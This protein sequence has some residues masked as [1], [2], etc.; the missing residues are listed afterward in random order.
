MPITFFKKITEYEVKN[1][2]A[3]QKSAGRKITSCVQGV[4][5]FSCQSVASKQMLFNDGFPTLIFGSDKDK[6]IRITTQGKLKEMSSVWLCGGILKETYMDYIKHDE[7]FIVVRFHPASF[8]STFG[9][10]PTFFD[11]STLYN[12]NDIDDQFASLI[13]QFYQNASAAERIAFLKTYFQNFDGHS[14]MPGIIGEAIALIQCRRGSI[15]VAEV[16]KYFEAKVNHKWLG[17]NFKRYIGMSPKKFILLQRFLS[18]FDDLKSAT[19]STLDIALSNGYY[20][21]MHLLKDFKNY[22]GTTPSKY[23]A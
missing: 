9:L 3:D 15:S 17:R 8:Y 22:S 20:D 12:L 5:L 13:D 14:D 4:Y 18:A 2:P 21:D 19:K 10:R 1:A 6:K 11:H 16:L 23:F 7:E